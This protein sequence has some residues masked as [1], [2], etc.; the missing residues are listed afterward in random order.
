MKLQTFK[1]MNHPFYEGAKTDFFLG[2][3][4]VQKNVSYHTNPNTTLSEKDMPIKLS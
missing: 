2:G 4:G 1:G 3:G